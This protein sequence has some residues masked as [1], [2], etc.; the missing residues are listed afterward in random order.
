MGCRSCAF[1]PFLI[2][3]SESSHC[4]RMPEVMDARFHPSAIRAPDV[5]CDSYFRIMFFDSG[6]SQLYSSLV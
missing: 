5:E 3:L 1:N 6:G 2:P 4:N